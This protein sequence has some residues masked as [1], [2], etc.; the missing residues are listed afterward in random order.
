MSTVTRFNIAHR[1]TAVAALLSVAA[2]AYAQSAA[3]APAKEETLTLS[4]FVVQAE[5]DKGYGATTA[6]TATRIGVPIIQTPLNIQVITAELINDQ[7]AYIN[8]Q[9]ALRYTSGVSGDATNFEA[10]NIYLGLSASSTIRGFTPTVFLRNGFRR[11][12][13]LTTENAE[14]I[15]VVKGPASV[16]FG[17]SAPGGVVNIISRRPSTT[18]GAKL[19]FVYGSYDYKRL[20][21]DVTGPLGGTGL[22]YRVYA[23]RVDTDDWRDF[24][25]LKQTS[26]NPSLSWQATPALSVNL[27]YEYL[28]A[29]RNVVPYTPIGNRT[30]LA[31]YANPPAA[32]QTTLNLTPVQLQA[33][34]LTN[35]TQWI[36][37]TTLV[38]GVTPFRIT[39][40]IPEVASRGVYFNQGGADQYIERISHNITADASFRA[41]D[42]LTFRYGV[43]YGEEAN[44]DLRSALTLGNGDG[45]VNVNPNSQRIRAKAWNHQL[46]GLMTLRLAGVENKFV[47]G[48]Q[49]TRTHLVNRGVAL[50]NAAS[51]QGAN[52]Y[53]FYDAR[54]AAPIHFGTIP[55]TVSA[56]TAGNDQINPTKALSAS[57]FGEWFADKRLTTL[58]GARYEEDVRERNL[59]PTLKR[60]AT[61]P[62]YGFTYRLVEGVSLFA[63]MSENFAPNGFR[64]VEGG[65]VTAADNATDLPVELGEGW[66]IGFKADSARYKLSGSLTVF[67]VERSN[68]PR[69]DFVA[70]V[71]DPRNANGLTQ[72]G[73]VRYTVASGLERVQGSE[74]D[75]VWSPTKNYQA[76][77]SGTWM[78]T[79]RVISDPSLNPASLDFARQFTMGRRLRNAPEYLASFWNKYSFDSGSLRGFSVG[80]GL[81][82]S[83]ESE[84][85]ANDLTTL[86][87]IPSFTTVDA[88]IAYRTKISG[89]KVGFT[90]NAVNLL[91]KRYYEG[92]TGAADP[93]KLFFKVDVAF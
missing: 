51:P 32:F 11:G 12:A 3:P 25:Y 21:L 37:D 80:G 28:N 5:A 26:F 49:Y 72:P 91:D 52:F 7:A 36:N 59:L 71:N 29:K 6:F 39:D 89:R 53:R 67:Q 68:I 9:N 1:L 38:T 40:F 27:E 56:P 60:S 4:P 55:F 79:A 15:E 57:W 2:G 31:N 75:I 16:F 63:S 90:V 64:S 82:Y 50:N 81:R 88:M 34:W 48:A 13:N 92:N 86:L 83:S 22:A 43:N 76:L 44:N 19:D 18:A 69:Q 58:I 41:A 84:P 74:L 47:L 46:D 73:S 61:S 45:T 23:S 20:N 17:Q 87:V 65:G 85:R 8:F 42:W 33:R 78:W 66:D 77:I 54:A 10:G 93:R 70:N 14:R 35:I 24:T 62:T 30:F